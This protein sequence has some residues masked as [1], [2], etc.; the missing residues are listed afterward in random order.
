MHPYS[1]AAW[2]NQAIIHRKTVGLLDQN[3]CTPQGWTSLV[4][5]DHNTNEWHTSLWYICEIMNITILGINKCIGTQCH[6]LILR[7]GHSKFSEARGLNRGQSPRPAFVSGPSSRLREGKM[8]NTGDHLSCCYVSKIFH[9]VGVNVAKRHGKRH[10]RLFWRLN[11]W[12]SHL[13][14]VKQETRDK[15]GRNARGVHDTAKKEKR[16]T[17]TV[18]AV[19]LQCRWA[20]P[21][22]QLIDMIQPPPLRTYG[23]KASFLFSNLISIPHHLNKWHDL[24]RWI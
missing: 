16:Y 7:Y 11:V 6:V 15:Y 20:I 13:S 24:L 19:H 2:F 17:H 9:D 4:Q 22:V 18:G 23:D 10:H 14:Q 3:C 12:Q 5:D 1:T 21:M 8:V